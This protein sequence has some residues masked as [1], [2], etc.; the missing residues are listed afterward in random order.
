MKGLGTCL[1]DGKQASSNF[2][3]GGPLTEMALLGMIAIRLKD[4][5]LIWDSKKT[6][7]Y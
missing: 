2:D 3:Y 6:K 4:Q 1:K 7:I 5:R